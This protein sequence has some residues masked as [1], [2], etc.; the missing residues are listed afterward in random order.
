MGNFNVAMRFF[1]AG[2]YFLI[3]IA[4]LAF[5]QSA[6]SS[7][8]TSGTKPEAMFDEANRA[9]QKGDFV[10]AAGLYQQL[11]DEGYLNGN[12]LYNLGNAYF[13]LGAK[14][15][16]ILNY[17]RAK[18]LI[19]GDADLNANLN[20]ALA[21]VQE[22]VPDWKQGFI[23]FLTGMASVEQL[24]ISGSV[25]FFGFIILIILWIINPAPLR[26]IIEGNHR[27]W[28]LMIVFGCFIIFFIHSTLGILTYWDQSREQ[29]V[30]V[31]GDSVRFEPSQAATLYYHLA[32][33]TRAQI[34]EEKYTWVMIKRIDGKRG[35]VKKDCLEII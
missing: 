5:G 12:L 9:Y 4:F 7:P 1:K 28:W 27:K 3:L 13:K 10:K 6:F 15:R 23:K 21:G 18:R 31:K 19:P 30:A 29:A 25:W 34:L 22:G 17:E 11:C 32:E 26:N 24:A 20:Y 35:W 16:A 2:I 33:G 8:E 14:G